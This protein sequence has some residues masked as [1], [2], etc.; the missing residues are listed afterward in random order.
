MAKKLLVLTMVLM[1]AGFVSQEATRVASAPEPDPPSAS[2]RMAR[3]ALGGVVIALSPIGAMAGCGGGSKT[4][5]ATAVALAQS[6]LRMGSTEV[7]V[8]IGAASGT[9]SRLTISDGRPLTSLAV[10]VRVSGG[11]GGRTHLALR[12]PDGTEI[13]LYDGDITA[14]PASF[15]SDQRPELREL[16]ARSPEG[17]WSLVASATS[18]DSTIDSWSLRIGVRE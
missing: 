4:T 6:V 5:S 8:G 11:T 14:M 2:V 18:G 17:V 9:V 3:L 1:I 16:L 15:D 7:P 13:A 12:H 10:D